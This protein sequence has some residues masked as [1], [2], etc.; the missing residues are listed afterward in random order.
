[1][2]IKSESEIKIEELDLEYDSYQQDSQIF[3]DNESDFTLKAEDIK[4]EELNEKISI[5]S[6]LTESEKESVLD[7]G[8]VNNGVIKFENVMMIE[9]KSCGQHSKVCRF[10]C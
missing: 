10:K 8:L 1:M 6:E 5:K 7:E 9:E 4:V 3:C 2:N